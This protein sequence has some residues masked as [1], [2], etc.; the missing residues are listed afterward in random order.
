MKV[1][2]IGGLEKAVQFKR[3]A[4]PALD[5][6]EYRIAQGMDAAAALLI[7]GELPLPKRND[8]PGRTTPAT[9]PSMPS[10]TV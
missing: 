1:M 8:S 5:E 10:N 7:D 6:P 4:F 9:F 3:A 2:G